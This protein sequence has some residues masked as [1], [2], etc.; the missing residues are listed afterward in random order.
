MA[1]TVPAAADARAGERDE[2]GRGRR[3]A[4]IA[5]AEL[6][7]VH[8]QTPAGGGGEVRRRLGGEVVERHRAERATVV[9]ETDRERIGA[10]ER[11]AGELAEPTLLAAAGLDDVEDAV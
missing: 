4:G 10:P 5:Q 1:D 9:V 11:S 6:D 3:R 8:R 7:R 2:D